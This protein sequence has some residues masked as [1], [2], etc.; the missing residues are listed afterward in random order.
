LTTEATNINCATIIFKQLDD[1]P[2][3]ITQ[4]RLAYLRIA[5]VGQDLIDAPPE[6]DVTT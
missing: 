3:R 1:A 4:I 2:A 5:E 6:H